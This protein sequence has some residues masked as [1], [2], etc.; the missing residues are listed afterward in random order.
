MKIKDL[1]PN[2]RNP[3]KIDDEHLDMLKRSMEKFGDI[4]GIV[5]NV[6]TNRLL[7]G[8]QRTKIIPKDAEIVIEKRYDPPTSVGT[9]AEGYV[10][11]KDEKFKYREVDWDE[12][13]EAAANI[14]ANKQG[15]H[16]D[17]VLLKDTLIDLDSKNFDFNLVGFTDIELENYLVPI[18]KLEPGCEEDETPGVP[19]ESPVKRGDVFELGRH[20]LICGDATILDDIQKLM[21]EDRADMVWTDPPYNVAYEG[22]TK[23]ALKIQNDEMSA[24]NF[25]QFLYD[26]YSNMLMLTKAGGAIYVAHADSE[27][28]NFRKA[29]IDSGWMIKQCLIWVKQSLVMG[30][31]DYHCK[32][33]PILYGWAP[34]ASHN[35]YADRK[36]TTVLEFDRPFRNAEHPTMKPIELIEYCLGN[37]CA[38]GGLVLDLFGGSGSTLITC[39]KTGRRAA[40]AELDTRYCAVILDRWEKYSGKEAHLLNPDGTKT[41]WKEIKAASCQ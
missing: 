33:E 17:D 7:G 16:W 38:P 14:A 31:Q 41:L 2:K 21:G 12:D 5:N 19:I 20:K 4:S 18:E 13:T 26:A 39:E 34:G 8:H 27:G 29:M 3:R 6:R 11:F 9:V 35:W 25:Y 1:T 32:H 36:Q 40:T 30:R 22:K 28:M 24:E 15:G 23:D 37:S 10:L